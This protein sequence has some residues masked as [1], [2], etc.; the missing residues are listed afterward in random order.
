M[1]AINDDQ[2]FN[3]VMAALKVIGFSEPEV[4]GVWSIVAAILH[5]GNITFTITED[6]K[7]QLKQGFEI[8]HT[9]KVRESLCQFRHVC[10]ISLCWLIVYYVTHVF[11][12]STN[13]SMGETCNFP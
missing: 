6:G 10:S 8:Q 13:Y 3:T 1:A 11:I 7:A 12:F 4:D 5:L 9:C 2:D